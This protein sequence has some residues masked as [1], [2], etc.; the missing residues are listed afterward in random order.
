MRIAIFGGA[1][2]RAREYLQRLSGVEIVGLVEEDTALGQA[3]AVAFNIPYVAKPD[4]LRSLDAVIVCGDLQQRPA[5]LEQASALTSRILCEIPFGSTPA[6]SAQVI[7][8]C[9]A[10]GT[11]L[12]PALPLRFLPVFRSLKSMVEQ[13]TPGKI[14][15]AKMQY[16]AQK[17]EALSGLFSGKTLMLPI[18]MQVVDLLC[19]LLST[20]ITDLYAEAGAGLLHP[21]KAVEDGVIL[22]VALSNGAYATLDVSL[23]LP[24]SYPTPE[25]LELEIIGT[26]GWVRIDAYRQKIETYT[27]QDVTWANWGSHPLQELLKAFIEGDLPE[28]DTLRAQ[29]I[30]M[31][32]FE[33]LGSGRE[34]KSTKYDQ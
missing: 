20:E 19:W 21:D 26:G 16:R 3:L 30:A 25:E 7:R 5:L 13:N 2:S 34:Q 18:I 32:V 22:S 11:K 14:L 17:V 23:S 24:R 28:T 33:V 8:V 12:Y 29:E 27:A 15:S 4:R 31:S 9:H 6:D 1:H 10:Q